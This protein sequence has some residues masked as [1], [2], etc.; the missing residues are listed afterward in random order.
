L[1]LST[2]KPIAG[3]IG[4]IL[5]IAFQKFPKPGNPLVPGKGQ[6]SATLSNRIYQTTEKTIK[7]RVDTEIIRCFNDALL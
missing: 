4:H 3:V 2:T 6:S 1:R 7:F 5:A